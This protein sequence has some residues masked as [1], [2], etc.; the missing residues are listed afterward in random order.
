MK[1]IKTIGFSVFSDNLSL[2]PISDGKC[3]VINTISP[4]SYGITTKDS[5]FRN[6]LKISDYLVLDGVYFAIASI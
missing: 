3:R 5:E 4:N 1:K 2:I 6:A